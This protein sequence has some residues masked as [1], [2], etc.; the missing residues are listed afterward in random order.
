V[1]GVA[2]M[3]MV[4]TLP[5]RTQGLGLITEPL[6]REMGIGRMA[7]A[8]VNLVATLVGALFCL[9]VGRLIDR[10]GSR[11]VLTAT[12]LLL[13]A[14]VLVMSG[15]THVAALAL[16]ITLTRG[17]G[18]SPLSIVSLAMVGKWFTHRF[19]I[20]M[21]AYALAMSV[22]FMVAFPVVGALVL[23]RGW[24]VTWALVG[25]ALV[26]V[27]APVAWLVDRSS[28]EAIGLEVDGGV[29]GGRPVPASAA[30]FT[31]TEALRSPAFWVVACAS[32]LYGLGRIQG[33]AQAITVVASALGPLWLAWCA[34]ATGSYALSFHV[35]AGVVLLV[36]ALA[37]VVPFPEGAAARRS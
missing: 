36:A 5:G 11:V 35:V 22:G 13:G 26:L 37:T 25:A 33:V 34:A 18:Q 32:A 23:E 30:S 14:V 21:A 31:M 24:R 16:G 1:L 29:V 4:G 3:A 17:L 2:A 20:A 7:F 9:G 10:R 28:L 12:A 8:Q 27:L 19:T 6:M 15:A